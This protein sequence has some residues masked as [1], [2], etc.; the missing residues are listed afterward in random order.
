[1]LRVSVKESRDIFSVKNVDNASHSLNFF[2]IFM[3]LC[4]PGLNFEA[5]VIMKVI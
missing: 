5:C 1:M 2:A 4:Y 3:I